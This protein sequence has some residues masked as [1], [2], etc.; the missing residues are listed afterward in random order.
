MSK[1]IKIIHTGDLHLGM[2]NYGK[3][4]T[5]T[6]TNTRILDFFK[7]LDYIIDYSI[8]NDVDVV[9][10]AGDIYHQKEPSVFI[11]NEFSKRLSKL[12]EAGIF[13][14]LLIGNHDSISS[15]SRISSLQIFDELKVPNIYVIDKPKLLKLDTKNGRIQIV[16]LPYI[17]RNSIKEYMINRN[18][19]DDEQQKLFDNLFTRLIKDFKKDLDPVLPS[20]LTAHLT[21]REAVYDNWRPTIVGNEL[22]VT[23]TILK[24][25]IFSY[26]ALGHIHKH[27]SFKSDKEFP[28]IAYCGSIDTLDFG[29]ANFEHGFVSLEI[30]NNKTESKF[31]T[32]PDQ[33]KF[34]TLDVNITGADSIIHEVK[35]QIS[36]NS[37]NDIV[38]LN[39]IEENESNIDEQE[40]RKEFSK[41]CFI[42]STIKVE[43]KK[44]KATRINS[45]TNEMHPQDAL[46][47]YIDASD[48]DF[49]KENK[50]KLIKITEELLKEVKTE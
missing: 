25:P 4:D 32:I 43:K 48:D 42:L 19:S 18:I 36:N 5:E 33:R 6:L 41:N 17:E 24:D 9:I 45:L 50:E 15:I 40:L 13:T 28:E 31:I 11:Q 29:E 35:K 22:Y 39:I 8:D 37:I 27:Q 3:Q 1:K 7:S 21:L 12:K 49:L 38:R 16:A 46:I 30:E 23:D 26:V 2:E 10:I 34:K 44:K 14:L 20:I 47:K